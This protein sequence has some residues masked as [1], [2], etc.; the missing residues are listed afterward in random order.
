MNY[1]KI[2]YC[3]K[4][5]KEFDAKTEIDSSCTTT[6]GNC[7]VYTKIFP[8]NINNSYDKKEY[9]PGINKVNNSF[10]DSVYLD[11]TSNIIKIEKNFNIYSKYLDYNTYYYSKYV[12]V[13]TLLPLC[14]MIVLFKKEAEIN[15]LQ[16]FFEILFFLII[17]KNIT[18]M[19]KLQ[20]ELTTNNIKKSFIFFKFIARFQSSKFTGIK[21]I[22]IQDET[23][24]FGFIRYYH[25]IIVD[26]NNNELPI[27]KY[28]FNKNNLFFFQDKIG[29]E[30]EGIQ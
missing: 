14:F 28:S 17:T 26:N 24:F 10:G 6:C 21:E 18:N 1:E 27:F 13:F 30:L 16:F 9:S 15:L 5:D 8:E 12:N 22:R 4:C 3:P 23:F 11:Q 29:K 7:K 20:I 2:L 19:S 25:L